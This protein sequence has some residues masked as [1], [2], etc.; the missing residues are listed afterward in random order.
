MHAIGWSYPAAGS[1]EQLI[2]QHHL[3]PLTCLTLLNRLQK[4]E[5]LRDGLILCRDILDDQDA[6]QKVIGTRTRADEVVREAREL[7]KIT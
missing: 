2:E 6:L 3:H 4:Q 1:L 5:L 7:L